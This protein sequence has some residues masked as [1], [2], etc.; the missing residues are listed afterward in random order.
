METHEA[1]LRD[2]L[3]RAADQIQAQHRRL[4]PLVDDLSRALANQAC[5]EAQTAAFRFEGA[6]KAHFLLE[7][8]IVFPAIRGFCPQST[9]ELETFTGDHRRIGA[10]IQA[11]I[12]WILESRLEHA[13]KSLESCWH[14]I[15]DHEGREETF[16][17][18]LDSA[19]RDRTL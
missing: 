6:L 9:A 3:R 10:G 7:E 14:V 8:E 15:Q 5:R 2:R 1:I 16:L 18:A 17:N 11:V 19:A 12:G 4:E 13:A